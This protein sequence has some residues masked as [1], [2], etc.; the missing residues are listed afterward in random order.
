MWNRVAPLGHALRSATQYLGIN[1]TNGTN[2]SSSFPADTLGEIVFYDLTVTDGDDDQVS[3]VTKSG[4]LGSTEYTYISYAFPK[5]DGFTTIL[6]DMEEVD[7]PYSLS[8]FLRTRRKSGSPLCFWT[9]FLPRAIDPRR[10]PMDART[11]QAFVENAQ[12]AVCLLG[13]G[14]EA[15]WKAFELLICAAEIWQ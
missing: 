12:Q 8:Q 5:R 4:M 15:T 7:V 2:G 10:P 13:R 1:Q 3:V 14:N 9:S 6:V 11:K